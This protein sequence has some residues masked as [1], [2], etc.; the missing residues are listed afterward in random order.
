MPDPSIFEMS[1]QRK[2]VESAPRVTLADSNWTLSASLQVQQCRTEV[3]GLQLAKLSLPMPDLLIARTVPLP[4]T[5]LASPSFPLRIY[6]AFNFTYSIRSLS[7][8]PSR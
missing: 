7:G 2:L 8:M 6:L 5:Q 1:W 3:E 4:R